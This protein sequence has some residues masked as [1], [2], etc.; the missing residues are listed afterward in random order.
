[1]STTRAVLILASQSHIP[2]NNLASKLLFFLKKRD[3]IAQTLGAD[4]ND[5]LGVSTWGLIRL[6]PRAVV[7]PHFNNPISGRSKHCHSV[8]LYFPR[9]YEYT[10]LHLLLERLSSLYKHSLNESELTLTPNSSF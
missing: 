10:M 3:T 1:M 6:S 9:G 4:C 8:S 7:P 2:D 5:P